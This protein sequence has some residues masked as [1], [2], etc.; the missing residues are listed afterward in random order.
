M[1]PA[2]EIRG[3][4]PGAYAPM[5]SNDG[6]LIRAKIVGSRL[7][8][9]QLAAIAQV[10]Q[11]C[12]NGLIDLSQRAQLQIRGVSNATLQT[13]LAQLDAAG[14]LPRDADAERVTNILVSPLA[15]LRSEDDANALARDLAA[16]LSADA[17]L[18]ALPPK[19]LFIVDDGGAPS[20]ADVEADIR[21][22]LIGSRA[23]IRV[24]GA[25]DRAV[26]AQTGDCFRAARALA[27]AFVALRDGAF[28]L[29]RMSRLVS[30]RGFE[31]LLREA[32]QQWAAYE[33][34]ARAP[35]ALLGAQALEGV[36]FAGVAAPFGRWRAQDL[37]R[38]ADYAAQ[39]GSGEIRITPWRAFLIPTSNLE[40]AQRLIAALRTHD[41][42][43]SMNDPRG[44]VAACPGAPE[45]PQARGDTR[46]HLS[47]LAPLAQKL[48]GAD[49]VGVHV[50]GCAKGCAQPR[51]APVTLL[52]DGARF[53]LIRNGCAH[54]APSA[55]GL[56]IE[57]VA[58]ALSESAEETRCPTA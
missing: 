11:H 38:L 50:A 40:S 43:L 58:C 20:L 51:A 13:A 36:S 44:A 47:R 26:F 21:I 37:G 34:R 8:A 27:R 57:A 48:A 1:P 3:W 52:V 14:V 4:C 35:H 18:K 7:C 16:A 42:I 23:M 41:L 30:E 6:L 32:G 39:L 17:M 5:A 2:P 53:D 15:G 49:G 22:D 9:R 19:F 56:D 46:S 33:P 31:A 45:C 24:A 28:D 12:G 55:K 25:P 54:D 29:R 10:S